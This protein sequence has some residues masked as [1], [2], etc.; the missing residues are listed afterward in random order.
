MPGPTI[1]NFSQVCLNVALILG[2][3][4]QI[5]GLQL[6]GLEVCMRVM[7]IIFSSENSDSAYMH[8]LTSKHSTSPTS[9]L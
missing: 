9:V 3:D 7:V 2:N 6:M 8:F 1:A 4:L 5:G